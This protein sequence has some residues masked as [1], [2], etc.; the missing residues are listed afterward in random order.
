M[1]LLYAVLLIIVIALQIVILFRNRTFKSAYILMSEGKFNFKNMK[2]CGVSPADIVSAARLGGY[3]SLGDI[4]T[5]IMEKN[6]KISLLPTPQKRPLTPRDFNFS[7]LR[8]GVGYIAF[9]NGRFD[10]D[11][12][13]RAG[14]TQQKLGDFL[15]RQG[16]NLGEISLIIV[17]E[18]GRISVF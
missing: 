4:D 14:M 5:A 12:L 8:E 17:S 11:N 7:P 18:S 9:E 3:F 13:K 6:G 16:Y 1:D 10:F 15:T 2:K